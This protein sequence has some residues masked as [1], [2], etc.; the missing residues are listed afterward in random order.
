MN[1]LL[2]AGAGFLL[3]VADPGVQ[4]GINQ[5]NQQVSSHHN[6]CKQEVDSGDHRVV[7]ITECI[8]QET[9]EAWQRKDVLND[10]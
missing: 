7:S 8:Q 10:H 3:F 1:L 9:P 6:G 5:V 2:C 4:I